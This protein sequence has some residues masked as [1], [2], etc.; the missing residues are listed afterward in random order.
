M[1]TEPNQVIRNTLKTLFTELDGV[2]WRAW[3]QDV[4]TLVMN[5]AAGKETST[6]SYSFSSLNDGGKAVGLEHQ[7]RCY[8]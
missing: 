8:T 5:T 1:L 2:G 7:S 3:G 6:H 4:C